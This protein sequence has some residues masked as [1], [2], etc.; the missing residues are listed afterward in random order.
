[1]A[2]WPAYMTIAGVLGLAGVAK[3]RSP[4]PAASAIGSIALP[5]PTAAV[6]AL[7]AAELGLA[8]IAIAT[9]GRLPAVILALAYLA[10][11]GASLRLRAARAG[12]GC[13]CFGEDSAPAGLWHFGLN[14][15]AAAVALAALVSP[16]PT[17]GAVAEHPAQL[18]VAVAGVAAAV[19]LAK[20]AF[21]ALPAVWS[22]YG[23]TR[24]AGAER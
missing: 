7:G 11:A 22:A 18:T 16:P 20:L 17:W 1:M 9:P 6:R 24:A 10:L 12:G 2:L 23:S 15:T 4:G 13:G 14:V 21:T 3:L 8:G 19:A 5:V